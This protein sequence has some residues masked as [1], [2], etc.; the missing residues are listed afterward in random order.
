MSVIFLFPFRFV[1]KIYY[2]YTP[3][4]MKDFKYKKILI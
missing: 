1:D 3:L 4:K 2:I